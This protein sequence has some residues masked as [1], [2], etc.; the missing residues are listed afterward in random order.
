MRANILV[1]ACLLSQP[2]RYDGKAKALEHPALE[3]WRRE[4]RLVAICPEMS[5]GLP[6]PRPAAEIAEARSGQDVLDKG[7]RVVDVTR[8]DV[9][10]IFISGASMALALARRHAC[11]YALLTDGSPSCGSRTIHDGSFSGQRHAG[12]GV[13]T[14]MLREHGIEVFAESDIDALQARLKH[15]GSEDADGA[16]GA[17]RADK[18][19]GAGRPAH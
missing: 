9:T 16:D 14:A 6:V 4:G 17:D 19:Q 18:D 5:A 7:A 2:V 3:Q 10:E 15:D 13:T 12:T 8:V 1:S 11:R